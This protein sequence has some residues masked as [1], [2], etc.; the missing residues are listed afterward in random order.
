MDYPRPICSHLLGTHEF[1]HLHGHIPAEVDELTLDSGEVPL[2]TPWFLDKLG[3]C[4][5]LHALPIC[6]LE[7]GKLVPAYTRFFLTYFSQDPRQT[8]EATYALQAEAAKD[9]SYYPYTIASG[10]GI[11]NT[12][13]QMPAGDGWES[14]R[15]PTRAYYEEKYDLPRWARLGKLGYLDYTS[16][17][18]PLRIRDG[19]E[20]PALYFPIEGRRY[21]FIWSNGKFRTY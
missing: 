13:G 5:V 17:E 6:R 11:Y 21:H 15:D 14:M 16:P 8:L 2:V 4:A 1:F 20:L 19:L 9:D 12:R 7:Q 18:L 3:G 10:Y